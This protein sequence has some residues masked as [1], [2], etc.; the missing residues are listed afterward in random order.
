MVNLVSRCS[1]RTPD[2][3]ASTASESPGKTRHDS[4][5]PLSSWNEQHQRTGRLVE[6]AFLSSYL[7]W[8]ADKNWSSQEWKSDEL[9]EV[10]TGR[11]VLFAQHTDRF[12]VET[13]NMDSDTVTESHMS[14]KSRSFLHRVNDR[15]RK[16]QYQ[17]LK[18]C[19]TRQQQ[20]FFNMGN[21][22][23]FDIGSI[24]IHG[25]ELP[26]KFTFH[27][28]YRKRSHNETDVRHI[29]KVD[30]RKSDEICGV[31][32]TNWSDSAWKHLSLIGDEEVISL[33]HAK[34]NVFSDSVLCLGKM[35][36]NPQSNTVWEDK[37]TS[38]KSSPQYRALDTID[39]EP[40]EF[41]WNNF[42]GFTTL[43]LCNKVQEFLSKISKQPEDFM[44]TEPEDF[45]GRIIFMSMFN[46][47]SWWSQ[48]NEQECEL[49][50]Q[51]V[52][53]YARRFSSGRWSFFGPGSEKKWYSTFDS[54]PQGEWDRVAE[55]MLI[56]FE[57]ADTQFSVP[58]VHCP[59]ECLKAKVVESLSILLRWPGNDWNCFSHNYFCESAQYLRSGLR[60]VWRMQNLPC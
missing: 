47:I 53:M 3:L 17:S 28:K 50:A 16:R 56:K 2:V 46:D 19:N 27:Q 36:E 37:L 13:D 49:S 6:D 54:K 52:S 43:Q 15:V 35:N 40:M 33:S 30:S 31:N 44:S 59:E 38:F 14:V 23:V 39:G 57:K 55:L 45:T 18:R 60:F 4:Q 25:K 48:D 20:T 9:M 12:I 5:L 34:V 41:E 42:P 21:V 32:T 51:L 29:W 24:C 26:R 58:R 1:E 7:E 11:P 8:N 10:R 22:Y